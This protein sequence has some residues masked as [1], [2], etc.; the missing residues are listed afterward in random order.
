MS[1]EPLAFDRIYGAW[2]GRNIASDA[3][4][5]FERLGPAIPRGDFVSDSPVRLSVLS[6]ESVYGGA[7]TARRAH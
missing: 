5:A 6:A 4:A 1:V 7:I 2:W 3:K